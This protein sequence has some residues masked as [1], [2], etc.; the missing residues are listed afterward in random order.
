[1]FLSCFGRHGTLLALVTGIGLALAGTASAQSKRSLGRPG[2][3]S[4]TKPAQPSPAAARD[5]RTARA[6][7]EQAREAFGAGRYEEA[8]GLFRESHAL[9]HKPVLLYNIANT[10]DRL[11]RDQ[12]AIPA[13]ER[14][15]TELP[16]ADNRAQVESRLVVL[17]RSAEEQEA[18]RAILPSPAQLAAASVGPAADLTPTSAPANDAQPLRKKWWLWTAVGSAV[19]AA[20]V[21]GAML[22]TQSDPEPRTGPLLLD[23]TTRKVEL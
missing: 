23:S 11:R 2:A 5:E 12:E 3:V 7:F 6:R 20:V 22:A 1:M 15:L 21:V 19:V 8:L 18:R 16:E 14:Y 4:S 17:R 10:L 9:S 13:Y